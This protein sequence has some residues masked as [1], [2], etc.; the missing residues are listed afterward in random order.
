MQVTDA[1]GESLL[2]GRVVYFVQKRSQVFL[3]TVQEPA[4]ISL[5]VVVKSD[6]NPSSPTRGGY[7]RVTGQLLVARVPP[8]RDD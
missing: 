7:T 4:E 6:T 2:Q 3:R 8:P 5:L 1:I